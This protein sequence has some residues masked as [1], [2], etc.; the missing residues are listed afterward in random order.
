MIHYAQEKTGHKKVY[1][2]IILFCKKLFEE[3]LQNDNKKLLQF[4][5]DIPIPSLTG[6]QKK[7]C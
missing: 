4:L 1:N 6:E 3:R 5:K 2:H 7:I